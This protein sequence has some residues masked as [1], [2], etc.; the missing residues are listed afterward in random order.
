[1]WRSRT[2][3]I[4]QELAA[5]HV[6]RT[7]WAVASQTDCRRGK[8]TVETTEIVGGGWEQHREVVLETMGYLTHRTQ[9]HISF[10]KKT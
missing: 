7:Q 6:H 4:G 9:A 2:R 3:G 8:W 5:S 10:A 1:M